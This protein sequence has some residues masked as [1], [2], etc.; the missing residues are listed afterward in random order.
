MKKTIL[1]AAVLG[2]LGFV[3]TASANVASHV[4]TW[5][6]TVPASS[7]QNGFIIKAS[8]TTDIKNGALVFSAT[9]DGKGVL[10]SSSSLDFNVF[11]YTGEVI[12]DAAASY[13]YQ[14]TN[15][16]ATKGGLVQEQDANGYYKIT[17]DGLDLDKGNII[18]AKQGQTV[19]TVAQS[20][21]A[22]PSNQP[23]SGDDVAVHATIVVTAA[24]L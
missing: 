24:T 18:A 23:E 2:A 12:G 8:D 13:D 16:G 11:D 4:F 22:T 15:L 21:A 6:G 10:Q 1:M 5:S 9:A 20:E 14:L 19:L 3:G 7:S 17:A